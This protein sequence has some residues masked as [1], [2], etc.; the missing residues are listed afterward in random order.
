MNSQ[1]YKSLEIKFTE[2]EFPEFEVEFTEKDNDFIYHFF[3]PNETEIFN[4]DFGTNL[5]KAFKRLLPDTADVRADYISLEEAQC[6]VR[7]SDINQ[8]KKPTE[9]FFVC[10]KNGANN[11]MADYI[12]KK[13]IFNILREELNG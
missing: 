5:E 13:K 12:L 11:P 3:P 2:K 7:Y 8:E 4:D 1:S 10:V 9:S 6:I